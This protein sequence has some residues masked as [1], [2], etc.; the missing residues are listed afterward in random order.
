MLRLVVK[1]TV[2]EAM[3]QIKERKKIEIDEVMDHKGQ[4]N[5]D[6]Q[7]LMRLFGEVGEDAEGRPFIV[8]ED[9]GRDGPPRIAVAPDDEEN[10]VMG[11]EA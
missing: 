9:D 10:V 6:M 7:D 4:E 11:N 2:D 8:A 5:I 3:M 1:H